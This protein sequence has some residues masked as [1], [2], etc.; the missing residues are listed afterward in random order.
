MGC[1]GV[2]GQGRGGRLKVVDV[3]TIE[4]DSRKS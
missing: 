1:E 4:E 3:Q 2:N